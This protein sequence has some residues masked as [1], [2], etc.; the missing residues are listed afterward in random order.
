[1]PE[2]VVANFSVKNLQ[3]LD[4]NG[5]V[6][7]TLM[8]ELTQ[9]DIKK[10]YEWM[11]FSRALDDKM[12]KLQR[13][14]KMGTFASIRGQEAS[15]IGSAFAMQDKDW[16]FPSFRENG[17]L[18]V[19]GVNPVSLLQVWGGDERGHTFPGSKNVFPISIPVG[20]QTLHAVGVAW[21]AKL[22]GDKIAVVVYHGDGATSEGDFSESLNF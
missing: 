16:M 2:K 14:G 19:R 9:T 11:V 8:P 7:S 6:D 17:S 3:I 22:K 1:M 4:E 20:S 13:S 5:N 21:A 18:Y 12:L 10:M 15:N